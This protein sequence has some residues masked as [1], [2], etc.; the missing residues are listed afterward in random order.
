MMTRV[1]GT[2]VSGAAVV[3]VGSFD[4]VHLG[5]RALVEV[6]SRIARC[7][8]ARSV[9][10]TFDPHP[11]EYL[12]GYSAPQLT[13]VTERA[14]LLQAAGADEVVVMTFDEQA[15][16]MPAKAFVEDILV[17]E[18]K[19]SAVITGHDHRFGRGREGDADLM[20]AL[21]T[22]HGFDVFEVPAVVD[23]YGA[24]SSS[25]IRQTLAKGRVEDAARML[26]RRCSLTGRV[27]HG[28]GR[29]TSIGFPTANLD[30]DGM[31][32]VLPARGVYAVWAF[33][34][35]LGPCK[36]MLNIGIRPT[37]GGDGEHVEVHLL[38]TDADLYGCE[39]RAEFVVR[40]RDERKF[41][42]PEALVRQLKEDRLRCRAALR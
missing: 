29:G 16:A 4:G 34:P 36:A 31:R 18:M 35:G 24:V 25:R 41:D 7:N 17:G 12:G 38:D 5:H 15:A 19:A 32:T 11:K 42:G 23:A 3:T 21:G 40:I 27:V 30:V 9:A 14:V 2:P 22:V 13:S 6:T 26:G 10:L 28:D 33:A 1:F 8:G 39:V 20:R 37:F